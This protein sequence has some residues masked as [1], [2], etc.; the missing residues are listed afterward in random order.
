MAELEVPLVALD[1]MIARAVSALRVGRARLRDRADAETPNP[2][3]AH[4]RA[5]ERAT[6]MEL[7]EAS[8]IDPVASAI[9]SWVEVLTIERVTWADQARLERAWRA[10]SIEVEEAGIAARMSPREALHRVLRDPFD[11]RRAVVATALANGVAEASDA[12]AI[13]SER[14]AEAKKRLGVAPGVARPCEKKEEIDAVCERVLTITEPLFSPARSWHSAIDRAIARDA[15]EGW[16]VRTSTRWLTDVVRGTPLLDG[17]RLPPLERS[18]E[19]PLGASTF[20]RDLAHFGAAVAEASAEGAFFSVAHPP[21]D[22]RVAR[23]AALFGSLAA[24][25]M[26]GV[27]VLGL[28]KGRAHDQAR[29]VARALVISLRVVATRALLEGAAIR[30]PAERTRF[31]ERWATA[32]GAPIPGSLAGL[33]PRLDQRA[34]YELAGVLLAMSDR[35]RLMDRFDEDWFRNPRAAVAL[36]EEDARPPEKLVPFAAL[37]QGIQDLQ[38][39]LADA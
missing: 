1:R 10:A 23:R 21:F 30:E 4:R 26:F 24:D 20:A 35:Q 9:R 38:R 8:A 14:R 2:L 27:R 22:L 19:R 29:A 32:L 7:A 6:F 3:D 11:V 15:G 31:E 17:L 18:A 12:A 37:E 16:P 25:A 34:S 39:A 5:S 13:L 28:G 36:R 33:V